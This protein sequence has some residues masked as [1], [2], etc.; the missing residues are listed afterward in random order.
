GFRLRLCPSGPEHLGRGD[1]AARR[2]PERGPEEELAAALY[3][4]RFSQMR[5]AKSSIVALVLTVAVTGSAFA[6]TSA[7]EGQGQTTP[8][9][10]QTP[11]QT[12]PPATTPP[13]APKP[14]APVPF[15]PDAKYAVIDVQRI[16]QGSAAGKAASA[17]LND[18]NT[19]NS[20]LIQ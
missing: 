3:Q 14:A 16:A 11:P 15:P 6:A 9:K 1:Q 8:P 19:K 4:P 17:K 20:A 12:Q 13:A 2:G 5:V 18:L 7:V 10:P